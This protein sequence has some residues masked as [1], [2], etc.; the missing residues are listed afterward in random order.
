M[1]EVSIYLG[2]RINELLARSIKLTNRF[3]KV[4]TEFEVQLYVNEWN[5][6]VFS[7][8]CSLIMQR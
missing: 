6:F 8:N 2:L 7:K 4:T 3:V 5:S 1:R